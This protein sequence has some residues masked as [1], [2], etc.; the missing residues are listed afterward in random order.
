MSGVVKADAMTMKSRP[1]AWTR[2][3]RAPPATSRTPEM[4]NSDTFRLD[5]HGIA[6]DITSDQ[7]TTIPT[8]ASASLASV[9]AATASDNPS[10]A[11]ALRE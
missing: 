6:P 3:S 2:R 7:P 4:P 10:R 5:D 11:R 8:K 9:T 1:S